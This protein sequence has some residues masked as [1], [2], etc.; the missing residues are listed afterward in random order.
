VF[1]GT[2]TGK[3]QRRKRVPAYSADGQGRHEQGVISTYVAVK[4]GTKKIK[5]KN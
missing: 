2:L 1:S 3:R 4:Q 5:N